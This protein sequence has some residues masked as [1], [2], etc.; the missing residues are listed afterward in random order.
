MSRRSPETLSLVWIVE[1]FCGD[2]TGV[3]A[4]ATDK[5]VDLGDMNRLVVRHSVSR[6]SE[7]VQ[8][9]VNAASI[10]SFGVRFVD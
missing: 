8:S 7:F 3:A 1:E 6:L 10:R 9:V 2:V 4:D 5:H